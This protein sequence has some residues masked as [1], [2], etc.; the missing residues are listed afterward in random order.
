LAYNTLTET[1]Y[2]KNIEDKLDRGIIP[3]E[4]WK[5]YKGNFY[6]GKKNN[7]GV[8]INIFRF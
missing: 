6:F 7:R 3:L 4:N 1:Y 2:I 5:Y 8:N